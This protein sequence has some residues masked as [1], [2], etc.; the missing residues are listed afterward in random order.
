MTHTFRANLKQAARN[1][2]TV[3]IG[4]GE[5]GPAELH[6][7]ARALE[8][9]EKAINL[10]HAIVD[11]NSTTNGMFKSMLEARTWLREIESKPT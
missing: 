1:N 4:G 3:T 11:L 9:G 6:Q 7:A 2:E 8:Q 10:L 5:F